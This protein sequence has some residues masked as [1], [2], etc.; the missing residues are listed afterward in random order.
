MRFLHKP[1]HLRPTATK[2]DL[3]FP[4][5]PCC[6]ILH[7]VHVNWKADPEEYSWCSLKTHFKINKG[8]DCL[9]Q[10]DGKDGESLLQIRNKRAL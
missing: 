10:S 3:K 2:S 4:T 7:Y 8:K 9:S 6:N 1:G 5:V